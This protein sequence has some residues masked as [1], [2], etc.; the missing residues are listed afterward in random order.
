MRLAIFDLDGTLLSGNSWRVYLRHVAL[1]R[2]ESTSATLGALAMRACGLIDGRTLRE[3]ALRP[4][5][6]RDAVQVFAEGETLVARRV[7][8]LLRPR[9][10]R[11]LDRCRSEGYELVLATGAFDFIAKPLAGEL[12]IPRVVCTCLAYSGE[13]KCLAKIEGPEARG[14]QKAALLRGM[15]ASE[16]V[17]WENS[18]AFSDDLEDT[19]LFNLVGQPF[20]VRRKDRG[21]PVSGRLQIIDWDA[22]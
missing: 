9:G 7:R 14:E 5:R 2:P 10:L 18:R 3:A 4:M 1:R 11:E 13:G 22:D 20:L 15:F 12:G 16:A 8:S 6:G 21:R 19:P 17:D